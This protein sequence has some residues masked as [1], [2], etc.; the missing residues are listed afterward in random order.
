MSGGLRFEQMLT[1]S[2]LSA[3]VREMSTPPTLFLGYGTFTF[4][5]PLLRF[6][7]MHAVLL[8]VLAGTLLLVD[9]E[10]EYFPEEI[11]KLKRDVDNGLSLIIFA[12]W[13]NVSVMEKVKFYDENTRSA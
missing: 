10:E 8:C 2:L 9:P 11:M 12:D 13:Y 5:L 7:L 6:Q 1:L 4:Y 3:Y